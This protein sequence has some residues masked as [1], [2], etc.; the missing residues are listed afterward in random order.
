MCTCEKADWVREIKVAMMIMTIIII[1]IT[2]YEG[3]V[4]MFLMC[5]IPQ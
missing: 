3:N 5:R 2:N 1:I 4:Y